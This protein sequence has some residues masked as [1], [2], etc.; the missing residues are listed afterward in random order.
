VLYL[1]I[2]YVIKYVIVMYI[3]VHLYVIY[4][5][6]YLLSRAV[7]VARAS[8]VHPLVREGTDGRTAMAMATK[9][10]V[11]AVMTTFAAF[12]GP[13]ECATTTTPDVR[14][15]DANRFGIA[16]S[17]RGGA[18]HATF[19]ASASSG[20]AAR[21]VAFGGIEI[22]G[23]EANDV[24]EFDAVVGADGGYDGNWTRLHD[25]AGTAPRGRTG[26]CACAL[27]DDVYV[28]GGRSQYEGDYDDLW[29]FDRS[30]GSWEEI[31]P[32]G[33]ARPPRRNGGAMMTP[34]GEAGA[35]F[36]LF[37]GNGLNDMWEFDITTREWS[38][39]RENTEGT[40]GAIGRS[41]AWLAVSAAAATAFAMSG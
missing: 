5:S 3:Y 11:M 15:R 6:I 16:P 41:A 28:F 8:P 1:W 21:L 13:V 7:S 38:V 14:T 30:A 17:G 34:D 9:T 37:G 23:N 32:A 39:V 26:A 29:R 2:D 19:A 27:R 35:T 33:S 40:S 31:V 20:S 36:L 4:L 25:G 24:W 12:A 22:D 10:A 18:A